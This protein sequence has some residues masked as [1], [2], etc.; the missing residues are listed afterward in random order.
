MIIKG[1]SGQVEKAIEQVEAVKGTRL[2]ELRVAECRTCKNPFCDFPLEGKP[3][4]QP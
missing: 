2:P 3:W 4:V 1:E